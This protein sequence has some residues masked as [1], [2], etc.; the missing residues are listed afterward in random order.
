MEIRI[1]ATISFSVEGLSTLLSQHPEL[2]A[3]FATI[4]SENISG[5]K[6]ADTSNGAAIDTAVSTRKDQNIKLSEELVVEGDAVPIRRRTR[7]ENNNAQVLELIKSRGYLSRREIMTVLNKQESNH[8]A[9]VKAISYVQEE[10]GKNGLTITEGKALQLHVLHTEIGHEAPELLPVLKAGEVRN[11]ERDEIYRQLRA[12]LENDGRYRPI[13]VDIAPFHLKKLRE[14]LRLVGF[15]IVN[16]TMYWVASSTNSLDS[17]QQQ[18]YDDTV[19]REKAAARYL[20]EEHLNGMCKCLLLIASQ[21]VYGNGGVAMTRL[22]VPTSDLVI[23]LLE[24]SNSDLSEYDDLPKWRSNAINRM[25]KLRRE[26]YTAIPENSTLLSADEKK[27]LT[28]LLN[29]SAKEFDTLFARPY[30]NREQ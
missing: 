2:V 12:T 8:A 18:D 30:L 19:Q 1:E 9:F 25:Y 20:E 23:S 15:D 17:V 28:F 7:V 3:L 6:D 5:T 27:L 13:Q 4:F 14:R 29:I 16:T 26:S 24:N 11:V 21:L 22:D 10:L